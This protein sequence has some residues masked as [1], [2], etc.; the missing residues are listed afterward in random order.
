[1]LLKPD[2]ILKSPRSRSVP[3]LLYLILVL[4]ENYNRIPQR[5]ERAARENCD[6]DK[7]Q[8]SMMYLLIQL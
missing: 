8:E 5:S 2:D 7:V 6:N 4:P 3:T 1:M